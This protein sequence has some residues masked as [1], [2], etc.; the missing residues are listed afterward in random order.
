[1]A[2]KLD[3]SRPAA[4]TKLCSRAAFVQPTPRVMD[5]G[6]VRKMDVVEKHIP[7]LS[8]AVAPVNNSTDGAAQPIVDFAAFWLAK[9]VKTVRFS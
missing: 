9:V 5:R 4:A 3:A 2:I 8:V 1:M 7:N 6:F